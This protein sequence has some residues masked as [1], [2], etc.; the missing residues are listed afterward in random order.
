MLTWLTWEPR[1]E[2]GITPQKEKLNKSQSSRPN[3]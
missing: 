2:M 3:K 1:Y